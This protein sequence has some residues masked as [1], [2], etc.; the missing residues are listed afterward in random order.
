[1][2][3]SG[4]L[5]VCFFGI[6]CSLLLCAGCGRMQEKS[7]DISQC[8]SQQDKSL[9]HFADQL[10]ELK[11]IVA[12]AMR[13]EEHMILCEEL[14]EE[15]GVTNTKRVWLFSVLSGEKQMCMSVSQP[16]DGEY[17][18]SADRYT[19]YSA[20]P[21]VLRDIYKDQLYI[22]ADDLKS[23]R[24]ITI[25]NNEMASD[26]FVRNH[27]LYY[28]DWYTKKAY[29]HSLDDLYTGSG[30]ID[31]EVFREESE[32]IFKMDIYMSGAVMTD[33][34]D[35]GATLRISAISRHDEAYH[36]FD[37]SVDSQQI[38]EVYTI[39]DDSAYS[40]YDWDYHQKF[41][42][43]QPSAVAR[44]AYTDYENSA[45]YTVKVEPESV[46]DMVVP[47]AKELQPEEQILFYVIGEGTG[48]ITDVLLWDYKQ[49]E[50][51]TP[52]MAPEKIPSDY[53]KE[54]DY[55]T[56]TEEA[57]VLEEK[58]GV[59]I[60]FGENVYLD[61][62]TDYTYEKSTDTL[63]I[64]DTL[65]QLDLAFAQFPEGMFQE[66]TS[67]LASGFLVYMCTDLAPTQEAEADSAGAFFSQYED[68]YEIILD[69]NQGGLKETIVHE[70]THAIDSYMQMQGALELLEEEWSACNPEGFDY[71]NCYTDYTNQ[72]DG[73]YTYMHDYMNDINVPQEW[74]FVDV[75]AKT[76][77]TEDRA[78]IFEYLILED[79]EFAEAVFEGEHLKKKAG[80]LL[81]Y[82]NEYFE[83]FKEDDE[84][85]LKTRAELFGIY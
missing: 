71:L 41:S 47:A 43:V 8:Q 85:G 72:A 74:Y 37:Y 45:E 48:T 20:E 79:E 1:M 65:E 18:M 51:A 53:I 21:F 6:L 3:K 34:S 59:D 2:K 25:P 84:Y 58:Y 77:A 33:V 63:L 32:V 27:F 69:M 49:A 56:L 15:D 5:T 76:Y 57:E 80:V 36:I 62:Y 46:Y 38:E 10:P 9:Y 11:N 28:S 68:N 50:R 29:R 19:V 23:Y 64:R 39:S 44:Y 67:G 13:D 14:L 30:E 4:R 83:C 82:C 73:T 75:Y 55:G 42:E 12:V 35:D 61:Y 78:R 81:D 66:M 40:W 26:V 17:E 54:I 7:Y 52:E 24:V 16:D 31:Y 22:F 70:M 60:I